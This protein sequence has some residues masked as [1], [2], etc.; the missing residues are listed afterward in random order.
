VEGARIL[1]RPSDALT[2]SSEYRLAVKP[3][4]KDKRGRALGTPAESVFKIRDAALTNTINLDNGA[5]GEPRQVKV[6][7]SA[8]G[9]AFAVWR[10]FDGVRHNLWANHYNPKTNSWGSAALIETTDADIAHFELAADAQGGAMVLWR[11]GGLGFMGEVFASRYDT[12]TQRWPAT[13]KNLAAGFDAKLAVDANGNAWAVWTETL[14]RG[15]YYDARLDEWQ[16]VTTIERNNLGTG[17]SFEA[18]VAFNASGDAFAVGAN[19]RSGPA[20]IVF[21]NFFSGTTKEWD[22]LPDGFYGILYGV[23]D[24]FVAG[25]NQ[26]LQISADKKGQFFV[27]WEAAKFDGIFERSITTLRASRFSSA[28]KTWLPAKDIVLASPERDVH[29]QRAI[30]D[31]NGRAIVLWT[32]TEAGRTALKSLIVT[33]NDLSVGHRLTVDTKAGGGA[34]EA[35]FG[36]TRCATALAVW[37]QNEGGRPDD[38][39]RTNVFFSRYNYVAGPSAWS[40]AT[41]VEDQPG[42]TRSPDLAMAPNGRAHVVW[43][44]SDAGVYRVKEL[45]LF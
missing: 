36:F 33:I 43:I 22:P 25:D 5:S 21:G 10:S 13:P 27:A 19:G 42:N 37:L 17:F 14:I 28:T 18:N 40:T 41:P 1:F 35:T 4:I 11:Q 31:D 32:Q 2:F 8:T 39:S 12:T 34:S 38:G 15:R 23:D 6:A 7:R 16:P 45:R 20:S 3:L 9:D 24:S 29:L 26:N 44:Q 30:T